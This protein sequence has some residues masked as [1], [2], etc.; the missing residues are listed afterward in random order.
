[1]NSTKDQIQH[2]NATDGKP[3][4]VRSASSKKCWN[5]KHRTHAFKVGKLTHYHC[6]SPTYEKQHSEGVAISPWET[7]RVFSDSCDEHEFRS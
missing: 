3:P 7:L 1:M 2:S 5:C 4:V 6:M